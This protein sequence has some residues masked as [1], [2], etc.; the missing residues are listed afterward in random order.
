VAKA[1]S[2]VSPLHCLTVSMA[3]KGEALGTIIGEQGA[4]E[5][6]KEAGFSKFE[7]LSIPNPV[8]QFFLLRK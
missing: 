2:G 1:L 5:L 6:A 8:N 3:Y 4:R 7:K